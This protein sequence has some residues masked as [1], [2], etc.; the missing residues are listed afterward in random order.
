[1]NRGACAAKEA[2]DD[3]RRFPDAKR[4]MKPP[5]QAGKDDGR[6]ADPRIIELPA[7]ARLPGLRSLA[8]RECVEL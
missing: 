7:M 2:L 8:A 5:L 6:T 4:P 3:P 1:M